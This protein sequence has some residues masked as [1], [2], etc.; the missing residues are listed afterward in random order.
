MKQDS[1]SLACAIIMAIAASISVYVEIC[2][3]VE[4][5]I[6]VVNDN[7]ELVQPIQ[8]QPEYR[9]IFIDSG[10][11]YAIDYDKNLIYLRNISDIDSI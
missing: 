8:N 2:D 3:Q 9:I 7:E 5:T 10:K 6:Q 11:V 4:D 1:L